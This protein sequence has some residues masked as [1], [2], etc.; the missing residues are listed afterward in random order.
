VC[1]IRSLEKLQQF[2]WPIAGAGFP[3]FAFLVAQFEC[4]FVEVSACIRFIIP[5]RILDVADT[6]LCD[7]P[8]HR[9][10]MCFLSCI[11][12]TLLRLIHRIAELLLMFWVKSGGS[13]RLLSQLARARTM[14]GR[15]FLE[16]AF[17]SAHDARRLNIGG[18][19]CE[20]L[21]RWRSLGDPHTWDE[22]SLSRCASKFRII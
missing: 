4:G 22:N 14:T 6:T 20:R 12:L 11:F 13:V 9:L 1:K 21:W 2:I 17:L 5:D 7:G 16:C 19:I 3:R 18:V 15:T 10:D 8:L